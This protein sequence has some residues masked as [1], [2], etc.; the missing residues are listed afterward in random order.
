MGLEGNHLTVKCCCMASTA[1]QPSVNSAE[2]M[3]DN[4]NVCCKVACAICDAPVGLQVCCCTGLGS[5]RAQGPLRGNT[6]CDRALLKH[7]KTNFQNIKSNR[8]QAAR[9]AAPIPY[10]RDDGASHWCLLECNPASD[11]PCWLT[12]LVFDVQRCRLRHKTLVNGVCSKLWIMSM[13]RV[14]NL[15]ATPDLRTSIPLCNMLSQILL[16]LD[17]PFTVICLEYVTSC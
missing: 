12:S 5:F 8:R 13:A 15:E 3:V 11:L 9:S 10:P 14:V 7:P 4:V 1:H 16:W 6:R 17:A 2:Q